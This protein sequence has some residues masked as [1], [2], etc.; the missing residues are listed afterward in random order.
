M[1]T[2][3]IGELAETIK[4]LGR[5]DWNREDDNVRSIKMKVLSFLG[6]NDPKAYFEWETK[7]QFVF[8]FQNY[9][10][11][12]KVKLA[13]AEFTDYA[14]VLWDQLMLSLRRAGERPIHTWDEMKVVIRKH[15]M[16]RHYYQETTTT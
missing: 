11:N 8:D 1:K 14:T 6:K 15:F 16:P 10:N 4:D 3:I 12:K 5:G 13:A 7:V 2:L 9:T